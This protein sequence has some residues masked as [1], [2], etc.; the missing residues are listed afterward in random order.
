MEDEEELD[1]TGEEGARLGSGEATSV[2]VA[3]VAVPD[4]DDALDDDDEGTGEVEDD[5][6]DELDAGLAAR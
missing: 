6:E 4:V 5:V 3:C 1:G 2:S